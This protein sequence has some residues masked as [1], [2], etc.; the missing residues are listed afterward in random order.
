MNGR[1]QKAT[2]LTQTQVLDVNLKSLKHCVFLSV[3]AIYLPKQNIITTEA[4]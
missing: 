1:Q 4:F 2:Q 3:L